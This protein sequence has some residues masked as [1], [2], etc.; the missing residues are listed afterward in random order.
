MSCI[1]IDMAG[2]GEPQRKKYMRMVIVGGNKSAELQAQWTEAVG[3]TE[4]KH[5]Y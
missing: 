3:G 4:I 5:E 2:L 1:K